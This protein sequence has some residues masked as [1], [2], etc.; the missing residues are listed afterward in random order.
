MK[1]LEHV[2]TDVTKTKFTL[3]IPTGLPLTCCGQKNQSNIQTAT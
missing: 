3:L 1:F 2:D